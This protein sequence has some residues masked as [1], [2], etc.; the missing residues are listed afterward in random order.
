[1]FLRIIILASLFYMNIEILHIIGRILRVMIMKTRSIW[2]LRWGR[3][4]GCHG[5]TSGRVKKS[6]SSGWTPHLTP[7]TS[8]SANGCNRPSRP[9]NQNKVTIHSLI[10][11]SEEHIVSTK[12]KI[13]NCFSHVHHLSCM[14]LQKAFKLRRMKRQSKE[15]RTKRWRLLKNRQR[16]RL[17]LV[18]R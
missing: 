5:R 14:L 4:R 10:V 6:S 11:N 9:A 1:M 8:N 18:N 12:R 3:S 2:G 17:A 7:N 16:R 13:F 15:R